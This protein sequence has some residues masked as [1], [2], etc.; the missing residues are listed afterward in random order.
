M[1][2]QD[3]IHWNM[4][5][6]DEVGALINI[7]WGERS[8]GKSYQ[9]KH[10]KAIIPFLES[11]IK[12]GEKR[13]R[14]ILVRRLREEITTEK[15]ERYFADVDIASLTN[16]RYNMITYYRREVYLGNYDIETG[17]VKRGEKIGYVVALST[18]QHYA[19]A[20]YLDVKN[21]IFEE[22]MSRSV[23][24]ANEPDKLMNFWNTVDRKRGKVRMW[25]VGNTISRVCPYLTDWGLQNIVSKQQQGT[26][27]TK[28]L[29]TGTEDEK[30]NPIQVKLAIE[31]CKSTGKS[32]FAIGKHKDMLNKGT[33]QSDPQP[34]LPKSK[35]EYKILFR[36]GF[37]YKEFKFIGE[38]L[39]DI[40]TKESV[41]FIYPYDKEFKDNL[42]IFTDVVKLNKR[43]QRNI[44]DITINNDRIRNV[45][46]T[47]REGN[48]FYSDDLCGTDFKQAIDFTIR[49]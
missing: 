17:K 11:M 38:L 2:K 24:L 13:D 37:M 33:W 3:K 15:V 22:F 49:K 30:G 7:A 4:D 20:S 36:I 39:K 19:G 46:E 41:W 23:Y 31:Y 44:Y 45:L 35:N 26:I 5:S 18:E 34:H 10:K 28:M 8:N 48:I 25:L 40:E 14:F 1:S 21:I 32:S 16:N 29:D 47:F 12:D 43:Y 42:L 9:V 27:I 6:L